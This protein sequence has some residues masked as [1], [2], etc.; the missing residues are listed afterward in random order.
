MLEL[1]KKEKR[2]A[3]KVGPV[4]QAATAAVLASRMPV[5]DPSAIGLHNTC[6]FCNT[7]IWMTRC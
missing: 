5:K 1:G 4:S 6:V 7:P 3:S 2:W